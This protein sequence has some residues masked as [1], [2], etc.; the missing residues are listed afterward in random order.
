MGKLGQRSYWASLVFLAICTAGCGSVSEREFDVHSCVDQQTSPCSPCPKEIEN[1]DSGMC[2]GALCCASNCCVVP[3]DCLPKDV[4]NKPAVCNDTGPATDC[5]G[6]KQ[7][8]T[9]VEN[10]CGSDV[11]Q[12]DSGCANALHQCDR[13]FRDI[14]CTSSVE[15]PVASC[16][17][18]C[19][20]GQCA[21]GFGCTDKK[22]V[23]LRGVG[24]SCGGDNGT[25]EG[26]NKCNNKVCC[27]EDGPS[28]CDGSTT[29]KNNFVCNVA[30][31]SC[32]EECSPNSTDRCVEGTFCDGGQI[33][34]KKRALGANCEVN[35]Q[36]ESDQCI[37]GRCCESSCSGT[38]MQCD[39]AGKCVSVVS[40]ADKGT[41]EGAF[42]CT[43]KGCLKNNNEVCATDGE[44][45]TG[46]CGCANGSCTI[47]RCRTVTCS[48]CTYDSN[49]DGTCNGN[50]VIH[51]SCTGCESPGSC[52]CDGKGTCSVANGS[53]CWIPK[54]FLDCASGHCDCSN[55]ACDQFVCRAE[56]PGT[57]SCFCNECS[58]GVTVNN[59][60]GG[61][62]PVFGCGLGPGRCPGNIGQTCFCSCRPR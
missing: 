10:V 2:N 16:P 47:R 23:P 45:A 35:S 7:V 41:C 22:C 30:A 31:H 12:D 62:V 60:T 36:C 26:D 32:Y 5:Q 20:P 25:C 54:R 15:Q 44:C 37:D 43:A 4:Y 19:L 3:E 11:V 59:C 14:R 48:P 50:L 6:T 49:G 40:G 53:V 21:S 13:N 42:V 24:E 8:A 55:R 46:T 1:C 18:V 9:C 52:A 29:C 28:C 34:R 39:A 33:C 61:T 17:E 27:E 38:C 57:C 58:S 51:Q 56:D